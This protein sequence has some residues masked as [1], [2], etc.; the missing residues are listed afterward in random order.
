[1]KFIITIESLILVKCVKRLTERQR[2]RKI[3]FVSNKFKIKTIKNWC[4]FW[5]RRKKIF[6]LEFILIDIQLREERERDR[7]KKVGLSFE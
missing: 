5:I 1:M 2:S 4:R 6:I 7:E 3:F